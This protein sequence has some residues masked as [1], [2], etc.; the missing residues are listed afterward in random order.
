MKR[1]GVANRLGMAAAAV[2]SVLVFAQAD[3]ALARG[4][5]GGG[6]GG[7][8]GGGM[9]GGGGMHG[10][11]GGGFH[12]GGFSGGGFHGGGFSGGGFHR[13]GFDHDRFRGGFGGGLGWDGSL[14]YGDD[15][16]YYDYYG[17]YGYTQPSASQYWYYCQNPA[18]YY[19]YVAQCST[20]WQPVPAG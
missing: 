20:A 1:I 16:P 9:G 17:S 19:P 13:G 6:G 10:G 3:P 11:G 15:Y 12:G 4:G 7:G 5:G 14:Y 18:G 8:H 2:A